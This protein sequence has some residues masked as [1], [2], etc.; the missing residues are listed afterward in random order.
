MSNLV[1]IQLHALLLKET[2]PIQSLETLNM[3]ASLE[4]PMARMVDKAVAIS[5][6]PFGTMIQ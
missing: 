1:A 3:L 5:Q 2:K 6:K 4:A